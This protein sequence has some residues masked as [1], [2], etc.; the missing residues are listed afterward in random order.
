MK[1]IEGNIFDSLCFTLCIITA[2]K[3]IRKVVSSPHVWDPRQ[4]IYINSTYKK[5]YILCFL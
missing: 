5:I 2:V 4:V 3:K 1:N